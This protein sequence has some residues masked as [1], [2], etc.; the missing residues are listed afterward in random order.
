M[1]SIPYILDLQSH[2]VFEFGLVM[3]ESF[4]PEAD[5]YRVDAN[6]RESDML[7]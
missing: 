7:F 5:M 3:I 1:Y 4:D 2:E 6:Q